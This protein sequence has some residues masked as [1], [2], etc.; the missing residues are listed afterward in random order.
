MFSVTLEDYQLSLYAASLL[1]KKEISRSSG[2][3]FHSRGEAQSDTKLNASSASQE[4]A[5]WQKRKMQRSRKRGA[6]DFVEA[7]PTIKDF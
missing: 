6:K 4:G 7:L 2:K 3:S 5:I 1:I